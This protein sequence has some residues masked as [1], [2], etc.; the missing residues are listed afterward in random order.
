MIR[1][2]WLVLLAVSLGAC[3]TATTQIQSRALGDPS[4]QPADRYIIIAVD[5]QTPA[6]VAR[7]GATPKGYDAVTEYGPSV[8][9]RQ[10][11]RAV[12]K[13][14]GLREVNAWPIEPLHV[15]CAVLEIP[16]GADRAAL[17][18]KLAKDDRIKLTQPLQTF[19]TRTSDYN[20]PYVGLQRGFKQMDVADAHPVSRGEGVKIAVID[21]GADIGHPDLAG[22]IA[23]AINFVDN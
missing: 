2:C 20:D 22:R 6:Y 12:E 1:V 4:A 15:H 3:A 7:A 8:Q 10:A 9:A 23:G 17:L 18:S 19:A 14:Y 21:T 13:D 11:M 5:N 16:K